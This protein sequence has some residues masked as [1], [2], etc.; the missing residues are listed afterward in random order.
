MSVLLI[1][2]RV[3]RDFDDGRAVALRDVSPEI[4][5]GACVAIVGRSR[6]GKSWLLKLAS[7][8]DKPADGRVPWRGEP[9]A[10]RRDW[11]ALRLQ[12]IG[13]AFQEFHRIATL[14]AAQNAELPHDGAVASDTTASCMLAVD[15]LR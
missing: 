12:E 10:S 3:S 4:A 5:R 13:I 9:V 7:G 1:F 8:I 11:A 15:Q 2:D 6:S 14:T